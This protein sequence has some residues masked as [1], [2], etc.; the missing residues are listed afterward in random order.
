MPN[1]PY[2]D[3]Y[4][5]E[6]LPVVAAVRER[7]GGRLLNLDRM[8]LHDH[9]IAAGW[10]A[11]MAPIRSSPNIAHRHR[12][13]AICAVARLNGADYEFNHHRQPWLDNGGSQAQLDALDDV[14]AASTNTRLFDPAERAVLALTL[15]STRN[16]RIGEATLATFRAHFPESV[17]F[18]E[19][20]MV[21]ASYNMV[22]RVL[23]GFGVEPET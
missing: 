16:V 8:L 18:Y 17:V 7:R 21:I 3:V 13:L 4:D 23:V 15:D 6:A 10:G 2:K 22:S 11:L 20:M 14:A 1:I 12:E 19:M 9:R 5:A